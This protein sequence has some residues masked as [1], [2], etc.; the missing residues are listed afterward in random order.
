MTGTSRDGCQSRRM[1]TKSFYVYMMASRIGGTL[2]IGVTSRLIERVYEHRVGV[3]PGFTKTYGVKT[4]V[5]H[6]PHTARPSLPYGARSS[7]CSGKAPG[8]SNSSKMRIHVGS[9]SGQSSVCDREACLHLL[10]QPPAVI[11]AK[12]GPSSLDLEGEDWMVPNGTFSLFNAKEALVPL[13][14]RPRQFAPVP[15]N[16]GASSCWRTRAE[17]AG[18]T[19]T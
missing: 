8:K 17:I 4:L 18:R 19:E 11:P 5:W 7:S 3:V 13:P 15:A 10:P 14:N 1:S 2:Y 9:I 16:R 12:P 6:E